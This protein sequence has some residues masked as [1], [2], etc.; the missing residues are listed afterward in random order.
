MKGHLA[1]QRRASGVTCAEAGLKG[2]LPLHP[3]GG[4]CG[5]VGWAARPRAEGK[6]VLT[7]SPELQQVLATP[8]F[9]SSWW[10]CSVAGLISPILQMKKWRLKR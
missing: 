10:L 6:P 4:R 9:I 1:I 8:C 7:E 3:D 2:H 5:A